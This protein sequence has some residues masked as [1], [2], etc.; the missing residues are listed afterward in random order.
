MSLRSLA[1]WVAVGVLLTA[2]AYPQRAGW[3]FL[4]LGAALAW[5]GFVDV[6]AVM[7][8]ADG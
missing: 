4:G 7:A 8:R 5:S 1:A 2:K 3:A 6:Y